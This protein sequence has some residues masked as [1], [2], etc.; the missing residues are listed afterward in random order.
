M[1]ERYIERCT[2][3]KRMVLLLLE[4]KWEHY[5]WGG[6]N[7]WA[8]LHSMMPLLNPVMCRFSFPLFYWQLNSHIFLFCVSLCSK[9]ANVL[10]FIT[11]KQFFSLKKGGE[12]GHVFLKSASEH[13]SAG[14]SRE[15]LEK[16]ESGTASIQNVTHAI[17]S[18]VHWFWQMAIT[19]SLTQKLERVDE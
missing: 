11:F 3:M 19:H 12:G 14:H 10:L 2:W 18:T 9:N 13:Y 8:N 6:E 15:S 4:R 17:L 1:K 7:L 5:V 16:R